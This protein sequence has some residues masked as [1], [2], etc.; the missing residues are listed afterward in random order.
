MYHTIINLGHNLTFLIRK[1]LFFVC[2]PEHKF[3]KAKAAVA[4]RS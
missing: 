4:L 1:V 2:V 3:L